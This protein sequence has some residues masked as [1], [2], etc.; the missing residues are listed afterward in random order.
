MILKQL[1]RLFLWLTGILIVLAIADVLFIPGTMGF[2]TPLT[3]LTAFIFAILH[4]GQRYGWIRVAFMVVIVFV[5]SLTFESVGV[6]TGRVYG[7]YHYT[8]VL[9]AKFLGLVPFLIP[10]AWFMMMYAALVIADRLIPSGWGG[11]WIRALVVAAVGGVVM[12]AWDLPM[13]PLM[14]YGNHWVWEVQGAYF[15]VPLQNYWGWWLTSFVAMAVFLVFFGA[16]Q[17]A[18]IVPDAWAVTAYLLMGSSSVALDFIFG[19][20]GPAL[21]GIFAILPWVVIGYL[22]SSGRSVRIKNPAPLVRPAF[23]QRMVTAQLSWGNEVI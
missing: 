18:R 15:G 9:G 10:L 7:P 1:T 8:D 19:L 2:L 3:T 4:G 12:T 6:A 20:P 23:L 17:R 16:Q 5:V 22:R 11:R 21:V 14:V 13:D